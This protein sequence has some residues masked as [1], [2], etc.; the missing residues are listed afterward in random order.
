MPNPKRDLGSTCSASEHLKVSLCRIHLTDRSAEV[1][2]FP[3]GQ[4]LILLN[5]KKTWEKLSDLSRCPLSG[6]MAEPAHCKG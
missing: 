6:K 5:F 4:Q 2:T 1:P 3:A